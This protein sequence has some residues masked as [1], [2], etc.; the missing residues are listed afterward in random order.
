MAEKSVPDDSPRS[1]EINVKHKIFHTHRSVVLSSSMQHMCV[2]VC[3]LA[4]FLYTFVSFSDLF[5]LPM[6]H[7]LSIWRIIFGFSSEVH[8]YILL[9][10]R[11]K[12]KTEEDGKKL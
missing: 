7:A 4:I 11:R 6:S 3:G 12:R 5:Y 1:I 2:F 10:G 8:I 9:R